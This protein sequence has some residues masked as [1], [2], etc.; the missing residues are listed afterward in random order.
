MLLPQD[1][2]GVAHERSLSWEKEIRYQHLL[3]QLPSRPSFWRRWT[4]GGMVRAGTILM[5]W[6]ERMAQCERRQEVSV[7]S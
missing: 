1:W 5:R 4:G 7:T 3:A 6:G 2:E